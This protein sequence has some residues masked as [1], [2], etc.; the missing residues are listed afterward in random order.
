MTH[1]SSY[2]LLSVGHCCIN[3]L[4]L[5]IVFFFRFCC[6]FFSHHFFSL[7]LYTWFYPKFPWQ[8][9]F[10]HP[11]KDHLLIIWVSSP[12][13]YLELQYQV[14]FCC[15]NLLAEL[16]I[17]VLSIWSSQYDLKCHFSFLSFFRSWWCFTHVAM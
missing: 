6:Y 7:M 8:A 12:T 16:L 17:S 11:L 9:T 4:F 10:G 1:T 5:F 14:N 15:K 3:C 2:A 13:I